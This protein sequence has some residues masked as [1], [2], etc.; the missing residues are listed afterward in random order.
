VSLLDTNL[1][2]NLLRIFRAYD[3]YSSGG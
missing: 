2:T 3:Q 1:A